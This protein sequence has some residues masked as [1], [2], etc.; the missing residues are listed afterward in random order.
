M[1]IIKEEEPKISEEEKLELLK[2]KQKE[3][4]AK[5]S[6]KI[7]TFKKEYNELHKEHIKQQ[8]Q[9]YYEEHKEEIK[10]KTKQ[11]VEE[12]KETVKEYKNEW[13]QKNKEKILAKNKDNFTCDCGSEVRCSGKA[14]HNKSVKHQKYIQNLNVNTCNE[15]IT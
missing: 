13:Y 1:G 10:Q 3:Y 7:K 2:Q 6:E 8:T 4:R 5:N 11:Y 12:N 14:E 15:I 9:K